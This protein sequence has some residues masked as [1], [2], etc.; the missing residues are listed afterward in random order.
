MGTCK[1]VEWCDNLKCVNGCLA[2]KSVDSERAACRDAMHDAVI[3]ALAEAG[4]RNEVLKGM[5]LEVA[6]ETFDRLRSNGPLTGAP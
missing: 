4:V 2:R 1:I 5:C 6:I 3:R